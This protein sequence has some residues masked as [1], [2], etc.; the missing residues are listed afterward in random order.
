MAEWISHRKRAELAAQRITAEQ[1]R[2]A[3]IE[4]QATAIGRAPLREAFERGMVLEEQKV[5]VLGDGGEMAP[6]TRKL[7]FTVLRGALEPYDA[8][9][10]ISIAAAVENLFVAPEAET[11]PVS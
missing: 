10:V 11:V 3:E 8:D 5:V 6:M 7:A 9:D 4:E 1:A 2:L